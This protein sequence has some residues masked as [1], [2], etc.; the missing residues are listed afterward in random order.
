VCGSSS[1]SLL[2][3]RDEAEIPSL[4]FSSC[5]TEKENCTSQPQETNHRFRKRRGERE[6]Y[7][8]FLKPPEMDA[9]WCPAP[10]GL[11]HRPASPVLFES[12]SEAHTL[13][14]HQIPPFLQEPQIHVHRTTGQFETPE[15]SFPPNAWF[16]FRQSV[17]QSLQ[18]KTSR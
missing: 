18:E 6:I 2:Q 4:P 12:M 5:V 9:I 8:E 17:P 15:A 11:V 3:S 14:P 7:V 1:K 10:Q 16:N 13:K